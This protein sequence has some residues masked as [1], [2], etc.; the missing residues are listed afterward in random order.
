MNH[1]SLIGRL[2]KDP[3]VRYTSGQNQTAMA[4]FTVAVDRPGKAG[5]EKKADFPRV[6]AWGRQAEVCENYLKKG[7]RVG[8]SGYIQTGSYEKDGRRIYTT[9]VVAR[10]VHFLESKAKKKDDIPEGYQA[11]DEGIPF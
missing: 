6:I 10:E 11:L 5:E 4:Q 1:V 8:I 7:D 9:D 2:T 3:E